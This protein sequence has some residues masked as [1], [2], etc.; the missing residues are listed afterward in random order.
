MKGEGWLQPVIINVLDFETTGNQPQDEIIQV[1]IVRIEQGEIVRQYSS[2]VKPTRPIPPFI[3]D[4]T[5]ISDEDVIDAPALDEV[6]TDIVPILADAVLAAHNVAFDLGFLQRALD[7]CG[8]APYDGRVI[9]L[10][11]IL[12]ISFPSMTSY[13]LTSVSEVMDI[14]HQRPHQADSDALASAHIW[15]RCME[16]L[17]ALPLVS[18][19]RLNQLFDSQ[20]FD[21]LSWLI[22]SIRAEKEL[23]TGLESA[24]TDKEDYHFHRQFA[25]KVEDWKEQETCEREEESLPDTFAEFQQELKQRL[26]ESFALYELR[27]AQNQ[28][29]DE[30]F[31]GFDESKHMLIEAGTGTG[32]SLGYLIPAVYYG[33]RRQE[34]III[35]THTINLQEQLRQRDVPLL[36]RLFPVPFRVSV[37]KGRSHYLCLRKFEH[38]V[39]QDEQKKE[40]RLTAA[41]MIVWLGETESGDE[42]E[43]NLGQQ[44]RGFWHSVASDTDSCLNRA[45]PWF[46]KC[47]YH[48]AKHESNIADVVVTNHSMLF[49]DVKAEHRLLPP[50]ERAIVDEAHHF[51]EVAEKHLG[52]Q[53]P[54]YVLVNA[55]QLLYKDARSG[56]LPI[57]KHQLTGSGHEQEEIWTEKID[58]IHPKLQ[59]IKEQWDV[60]TDLLYQW[61]ES[62]GDAAAEGGQLTKRLLPGHAY[63][64]WDPIRSAEE[65]MYTEGAVMLRE[66]ESLHQALKEEWEDDFQINSLLTDLHGCIKDIRHFRDT[67]HF[68][69]EMSNNDYVY[70][71]EGSPS[72][73][74]KSLQLTAV[75]I[76]VSSLLQ[77]Y[78]F[79]QKESLVLTSA[80]LTVHKSFDF[81]SAQLGL[82]VY[83]E[84]GKLRTLLLPSPFEYRKQ[85]LVCIPRD[86]PKIS[87]SGEGIFVD[88]LVSSLSEIAGIT[89]GRMLVL[90]TSYRMLRQ[91]HPLL[92]EKLSPLQIDVLGQGLDGAN[93]TK[94]TRRF[95]QGRSS[96]LL[97]TSSF[98]EGVDLPGD[99][100]T[101]L[102]IVRLPFQPPNHPVV[103]AKCEAIKQNRQNPFMKY[104]VPQAVIRFKQGFGRLVR[105]S[106]DRG[107]AIIYDTRIIETHYGKNFL[108]SLPGPKIEHM[109]TELMGARVAEWM[110]VT[111]VTTRKGE[112]AH[113]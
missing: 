72:F 67:L 110:E 34:K 24:S 55:S 90:F 48:R 9:D 8:Y 100:L 108:Y 76:D 65:N 12:K 49:T 22:E 69:I 35:S 54:Y 38:T 14:E 32:K 47:Y 73:K 79:E 97:G 70:W 3:T 106:S 98:W 80:T 113:V 88:H 93:R 29:M 66:L 95:Q 99:A 10:M 1:G 112:D 94:L 52:Q 26:Q 16:K 105:T 46:K 74:H 11:D 27:E 111:P 87:G 56:L 58:A 6:I 44:G 39:N 30:V 96:V 103:E 60:V 62:S 81:A 86:F 5:G 13:Q 23:Q 101:C 107:V 33:V 89:K 84:S 31:K 82:K 78:F 71:M 75:P 85:A 43:I 61:L 20:M 28:M 109:R 2:L 4:L 25:L 15:L 40:D 68:W 77:Q 7:F 37:L 91:V 63:P 104:S 42:E 36:Q 17:R 59:S 102:A 83:E 50:Y 53:L 41:Q 51:E 18:L 21:H 64:Q 45:C 92:R 19:Q 57:L